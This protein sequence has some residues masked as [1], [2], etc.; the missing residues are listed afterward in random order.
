MKKKCVEQLLAVA[1]TKKKNNWINL[2]WRKWIL[3]W[4]GEL[5]YL[6]GPKEDSC[7]EWQTDCQRMLRVQTQFGS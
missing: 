1:Q 4:E 2:C 6:Y 5:R 7:D 3:V